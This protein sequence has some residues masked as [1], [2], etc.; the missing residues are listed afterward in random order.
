MVYNIV[1]LGMANFCPIA[2]G[3]ISQ[4][5]GW[6]M[7]FK[8]L[9]AFTGLAL[10]LIIFACPE[11]GGYNRAAIYETDVAS[12]TGLADVSEKHSEKVSEKVSEEKKTDPSEN[13]STVGA[14]PPT[15]TEEMSTEKPKTY[16]QELKPFDRLVLRPNP[17]ILALRPFAC[18][19]Y[20]AVFWGFTVGGLWS[21]WV[22]KTAA[23]PF[24][25]RE[26]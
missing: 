15:T 13:S 12:T 19:L 4:T 10:L 3:Y 21:S 9:I 18:F 2:G 7:Q 16:F 14:G 22:S 11:H 26:T 1:T 6:R 5:Y 20:P 23:R 25:N 8:I 17:F 24:P